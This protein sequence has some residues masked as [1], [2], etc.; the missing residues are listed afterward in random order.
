MENVPGMQSLCGEN[1]ADQVGSDLAESGYRV[2]YAVLN[3]V[4]YGV[5]QFRERLFFVGIRSDLGVS[6]VM[7]SAMHRAATI[8]LGY[9]SNG[10]VSR[11]SQSM[12]YL[13]FIM[14]YELTVNQGR[15]KLPATSVHDALDD[16]PRL[17]D[18]LLDRHLPRGDFRRS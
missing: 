17:E 7:P 11:S 6:P 15:A 1:V 8:P 5:P 18:H 14:H 9:S 16:L 4:W 10:T 2:G 13:P 12:G 3:S